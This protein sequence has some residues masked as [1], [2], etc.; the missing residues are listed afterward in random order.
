MGTPA[1]AEMPVASVGIDGFDAFLGACA[2][3]AA[4]SGVPECPKLL[5][6]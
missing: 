5:Q 6:R 4:S 2:W 3:C 1:A